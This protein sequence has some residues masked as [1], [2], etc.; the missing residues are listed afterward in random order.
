MQTGIFKHIPHL[1]T[2][3]SFNLKSQIPKASALTSLQ[4]L[5]QAA[6]GQRIVVGLSAGLCKTLAIKAPKELR[7]FTTPKGAKL[8]LPETPVDL[9]VWLR[10]TPAQDRG[11]LLAVTRQIQTMLN[12]AFA[13]TEAVEAFQHLS[14]IGTKSKDLTG[15]EDGTENPK[16][17]KAKD[18]GFA[19]DGSSFLAL[20]KW[21]HKWGN[22]A[23]MSP[24]EQNQAIGRNKLTNAELESAPPSAHIKR[25]TQEDFTLSDGTE[26]FTLRRSMPWSDGTNSG[27]MFAAFGK[28]F[29]AFELQ[30]KRMVGADD[31]ITDAVFKMSKPLT[32]SFF[33]CPPVVNGKIVCKL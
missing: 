18:F 16:G 25:T 27:L 33:W 11:D 22:I 9:L 14:K 10:A 6:D 1:A 19:A 3:L 31:G 28:S 30:L 21:Q 32:G 29:E 26:G 13:L 8:V 23:K 12:D 20:Q 15:F 7:T 2:Y 5:L 24:T 4:Q 17:Q